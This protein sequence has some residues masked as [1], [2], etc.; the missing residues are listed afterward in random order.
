M[1]FKLLILRS[2][3]MVMGKWVRSS[4]LTYISSTKTLFSLPRKFNV[5]QNTCLER[6]FLLSI[7]INRDKQFILCDIPYLSGNR[8]VAIRTGILKSTF[9]WIFEREKQNNANYDNHL[10]ISDSL[11]NSNVLFKSVW[12]RKTHLSYSCLNLSFNVKW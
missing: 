8:S 1:V 5:L 12:N 7:H 11:I 3:V 2:V 10:Y 9:K 6:L 4:C